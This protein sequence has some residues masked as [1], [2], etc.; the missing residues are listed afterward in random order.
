MFKLIPLQV[1]T[2][3]PGKARIHLNV[4]RWRVCESWFS[5]TMAGVDS[6]GIGEVLQN[7]LSR[8]S[9][10]EKGRLV[11][12]RPFYRTLPNITLTHLCA[13]E[14]L[15]DRRPVSAPGPASAA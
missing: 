2:I 8:F 12:V 6:A 10:A 7:I 3:R 14:R 13:L 11:N 5:P 4:E 9:D 15:C 1:L